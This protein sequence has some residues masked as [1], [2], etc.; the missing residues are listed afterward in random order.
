MKQ[1]LDERLTTTQLLLQQQE[2]AARR[3][4]RERRALS[5]RVKDLER[6]LHAL[7]V[8]KKHTQV[9]RHTETYGHTHTHGHLSPSLV[10]SVNCTEHPAGHLG[11]YITWSQF[12]SYAIWQRSTVQEHSGAISCGPR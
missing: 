2:E 3:G 6:A 5:D 4:E 11:Y 7:E 8:D 9:H 12:S 10:G 1:G